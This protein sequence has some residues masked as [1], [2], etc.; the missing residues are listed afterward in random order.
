MDKIFYIVMM[1]ESE[2]ILISTLSYDGIMYKY[3]PY[4]LEKCKIPRIK[5]EFVSKFP[6]HLF[7]RRTFSEG[8]PDIKELLN[9]V[10]LKKYDLWQL[11]ELHEGA[12]KTD[13]IKF[14]TL[15]G[16]KKYKIEHILNDIS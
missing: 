13:N 12:L 1:M 11:V 2:N 3:K 10:G 8:R 4:N 9:K 7:S 15:H 6:P 16:L 14:L 5:H